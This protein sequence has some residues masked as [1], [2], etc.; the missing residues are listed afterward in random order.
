MDSGSGI[1]T[2]EN[3]YIWVSFRE[4]VIFSST[5]N[6]SLGRSRASLSGQLEHGITGKTYTSESLLNMASLP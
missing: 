1:R 2:I 6:S 4:C 3:K 5:E